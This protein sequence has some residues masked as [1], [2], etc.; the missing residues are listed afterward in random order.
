MEEAVLVLREQTE[1]V[2]SVKAWADANG[3]HSSFVGDVLRGRRE[4]SERLLEAMGVKKV[5]T[6]EFV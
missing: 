6:Y 5:V 1:R 4:P 2:N 3:F